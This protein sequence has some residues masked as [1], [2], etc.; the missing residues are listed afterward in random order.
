MLS[1]INAFNDGFL[2]NLNQTQARITEDQK[3]ISSGVRVSQASDDPSSVSSILDYQAEIS[4]VTQVKTNM[5]AATTNA[6]AADSALQ[7]AS[8]LLDQLVSIGAQ[9]SSST[10][11]A[12]TQASLANQ[13]QQIAQQFVAIANT[14]S[15][16][17]FVFGGDAGGTPP[18][19][20]DWTSPKGVVQ[21]STAG[22]TGVLR[23]AGGNQIVAGM[24][25][26]QI[27]DA[28]SPGGASAQGNVFQAVYDLGTALAV[29]NNQAAI[30]TATQEVKDA[31][32]QIGQATTAYG[33]TQN[34]I[35]TATADAADRLV[36]LQQ[37]LSAVRDTDVATVAIQ[38]TTDNTALQA[39][40]S[41][42]ASLSTKSLF[43]FL[44]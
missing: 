23:D 37:G 35:Q 9:G 26:Q 18:Y 6:N 20:F 38:L 34:W 16:G 25:A 1:G 4:R 24:T 12:T 44:G 40:L 19:T 15:Q 42:H 22:S 10:T 33:N 11:S 7:S 8:T 32:T 13:V 29:P 2:A 43:S 30:A 21:N 39:A 17:R 3:Q 14:S 5:N 36:G 27:F 28:Q 41:A 31:L